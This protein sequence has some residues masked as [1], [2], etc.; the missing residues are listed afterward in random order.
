VNLATET[1]TPNYDL[2][3]IKAEARALQSKVDAFEELLDA[4]GAQQETNTTRTIEVFIQEVKELME[5]LKERE[6]EEGKVD[7]TDR[8]YLVLKWGIEESLR[9]VDR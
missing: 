5:Y 7:L 2:K 3:A 8:N 9:E 1:I 4:Y 6:R